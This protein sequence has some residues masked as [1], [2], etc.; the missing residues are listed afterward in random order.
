MFSTS[1]WRWW[2]LA[3]PILTVLAVVATGNHWWF[4]GIVSV[5]LIGLAIVVERSF[6]AAL[7]MI[8]RPAARRPNHRPSCPTSPS[9]PSKIPQVIRRVTRRPAGRSPAEPN[10]ARC[11]RPASNASSSCPTRPSRGRRSA[12]PTRASSTGG[13]RSCSATRPASPLVAVGGYGRSELAPG[14]DLDVILVHHDRR[15]VDEIAQ[16]V[17]YPI[18]E[19]GIAL[20]HSV[21]TVAGALDIATAISKPASDSSTRGRSR[22]TTSSGAS[23]AVRPAPTGATSVIGGYA[24]WMTQPRRVSGGAAMSRFSSSRI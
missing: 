2:I 4:D 21:K 22:E 9:I 19:E 16:R 6:H 13:W 5:W 7:L 10:E 11:H 3:H 1:R 14:S 23:S 18:W 12:R 17:W 20:D 8:A 15:D 24:S